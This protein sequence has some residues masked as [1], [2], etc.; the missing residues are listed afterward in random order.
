MI[1]CLFGVCSNVSACVWNSNGPEIN[2]YPNAYQATKGSLEQLSN[3]EKVYLDTCSNPYIAY[4]GSNYWTDCRI[5]NGFSYPESPFKIPNSYI[6]CTNKY[7]GTCSS[8]TAVS[9]CGSPEKNPNDCNK[10]YIT[11]DKGVNKFCGY[12]GYCRNMGADCQ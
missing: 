1:L 10:S 2:Y 8:R 3:T 11:D 9:S 4:Y 12:E 6:S 7:V 5:T